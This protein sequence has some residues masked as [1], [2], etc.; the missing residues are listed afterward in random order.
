MPRC[1]RLVEP[2]YLVTVLKEL[3]SRDHLRVTVHKEAI[4]LLGTY[5]SSASIPL[6]RTQWQRPSI[7]RDVQIAI[8][9]AARNLLNHEEAWLFLEEMVQSEDID[10]TRSL[11][12]QQPSALAEAARVR[13]ARLLVK[14]TQHTEVQ[15][16]REAFIALKA[17]TV[18]V[19]AEI[20]AAAVSR[21]IDLENSPE[22]KS[23]LEVLLT[24]CR[25][26][27]VTERLDE[28]VQAV[29]ATS[30]CFACL[31]VSLHAIVHVFWL[32]YNRIRCYSETM[33][34]PL[35]GRWR[36]MRHWQRW[37]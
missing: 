2:A 22:W 24:C 37:Y 8:G 5:A 4:R 26:G 19:E 30:K 23:A 11:C 34:P 31:P 10:I 35:V 36:M 27:A 18:G 3:L 29:I 14:L 17:W 7:H 28:V 33:P 15:V 6:L 32:P 1:A 12:T 25:D 21:I 16:R 9:H 13:Y 20:A